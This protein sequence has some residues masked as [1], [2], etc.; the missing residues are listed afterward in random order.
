MDSWGRQPPLFHSLWNFMKLSLLPYKSTDKT[1]FININIIPLL[2]QQ[3]IITRLFLAIIECIIFA[4]VFLFVYG[5]VSIDQ[6]VVHADILSKTIRINT[7]FQQFFLIQ[8]L[9]DK[10]VLFRDFATLK[11]FLLFIF[12][13]LT[14]IHQLFL[15]I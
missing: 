7:L 2:T 3:R 15:Q 14:S 11:D 9:F 6:W 10:F 8:F 4:L 13:I 1:N 5:M 12:I